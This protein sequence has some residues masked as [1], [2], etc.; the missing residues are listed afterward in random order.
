MYVAAAMVP[1]HPGDAV[2]LIIAARAAQMLI[3]MAL[4]P[5]TDQKSAIHNVLT[6]TGIRTRVHVVQMATNK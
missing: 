2:S 6:A 3:G 4:A 5:R 1:V